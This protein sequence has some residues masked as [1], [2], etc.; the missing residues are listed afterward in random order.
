[1]V[2]YKTDADLYKILSGRIVILVV[3]GAGLWHIEENPIVISI[4][5]LLLIFAFLVYGNETIIVYQDRFVYSYG[6]LLKWIFSKKVYYYKDL[7][8]VI[9]DEVLDPLEVITTNSIPHLNNCINIIYKNDETK[10]LDSK[11]GKQDLAGVTR[12]I[13]YEI[14]KYSRNKQL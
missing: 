10:R 2:V 4:V 7:K 12:I 14:D 13:N 6:S 11:I 3:I 9:Y 1:M 8:E 5:V